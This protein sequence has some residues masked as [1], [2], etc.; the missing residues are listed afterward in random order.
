[1]SLDLLGDLNWLAVIVATVVYFVL[2]AAWFSPVLF[3]EPWQRSIG[4]DPEA[5]P[6]QMSP[7]TYVIPLVGY[8]LAAVATA[9]I[10][11]AAG[12]DGVGDGIVLGLVVGV[13][14][15][16]ALTVTEAT[17][18]PHKPQPWQWFAITW[19]YHLVGLVLVAVIV[20]VWT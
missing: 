4:W 10:A 3:A 12:S 7:V 5:Q 20:S 9:M 6:P 11:V 17:F 15:G 14:F 1:M 18:D 2:G 13:G 19:A 16:G 8:L